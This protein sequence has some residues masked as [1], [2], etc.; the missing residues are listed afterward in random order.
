M[1]VIKLQDGMGRFLKIK[2]IFLSKKDEA[3]SLGTS[4]LTH[5]VDTSHNAYCW[6]LYDCHN[7]YLK[8]YFINR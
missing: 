3:I 7:A 8:I 5:D 6:F 2:F 4:T 1:N